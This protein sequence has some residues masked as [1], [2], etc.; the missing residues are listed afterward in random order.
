MHR[1]PR[2]R[3]AERSLPHGGVGVRL[4]NRCTAEAGGVRFDAMRPARV[5]A[6]YRRAILVR[7]M[8]GRQRRFPASRRPP[9]RLRST[10]AWDAAPLGV[11]VGVHDA[12]LAPASAS[13][14]QTAV[15]VGIVRC[16][17]VRRGRWSM[18]VL[19]ILEWRRML[20][21]QIRRPLGCRT[22]SGTPG[23]R[24]RTAYRCSARWRRVAPYVRVARACT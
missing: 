23:T 18:L 22:L 13:P 17:A 20:V 5:W 12:P 14:T 9:L 15:R 7:H 6:E 1:A 10:C 24:S 11:V 4:W 21:L 19:H 8:S 3:V 16:A 2:R